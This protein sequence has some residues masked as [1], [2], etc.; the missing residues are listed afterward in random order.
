MT[1]ETEIKCKA[2]Q[3][4]IPVTVDKNNPNVRDQMITLEMNLSQFDKP[5]SE[6]I[7]QGLGKNLEDIEGVWDVRDLHA[8]DTEVRV[9][10]KYIEND[11]KH[12]INEAVKETKR[13]VNRVVDREGLEEE[14]VEYIERANKLNIKE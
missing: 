6:R 8:H 9:T 14:C 3:E 7:S 2:A 1:E 10:V 11:V 13:I 5:K 12:S 4:P